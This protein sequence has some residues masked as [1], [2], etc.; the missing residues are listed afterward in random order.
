MES[1]E[2]YERFEKAH[3]QVSALSSELPKSVKRLADIYGAMMH[4]ATIPKSMEQLNDVSLLLMEMSKLNDAIEGLN[5]ATELLKSVGAELGV[6]AGVSEQLRE[7]EERVAS[8]R[9]SLSEVGDN[10][11]KLDEV[12]GS[13]V[14]NR[15]NIERGG[16]LGNDFDK[17]VKD[18]ESGVET[19]KR[20]KEFP[21]E[22]GNV[23]ERIEMMRE[24]LMPLQN[25]SEQLSRDFTVYVDRCNYCDDDGD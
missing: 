9:N 11:P 25:I 15:T 10:A 24:T 4:L 18:L 2:F 5:E 13:I 14:K 1:E 23:S 20:F 17:I 3:H 16:K 19:L 12:L 6:L 7:L 21:Q 8:A 22:M